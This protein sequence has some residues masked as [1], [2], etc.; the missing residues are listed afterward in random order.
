MRFVRRVGPLLLG[1]IGL[2]T[3]AYF[4]ARTL[5]GTPAVVTPVPSESPSAVASA[6]PSAARS[7]APVVSAPPS[8][9]PTTPKIIATV[10]VVRADAG[11]GPAAANGKKRS[12]SVAS[13]RPANGVFVSVDGAPP[14]ETSQDVSFSLDEKSHALTFTC[15]RDLCDPRTYDVP[16]GDK[17][18]PL[19]VALHIHPGKLL[20]EGDPTHSYGIDELP[21]VTVVPGVAA[22]IPMMTDG[23]R[24]ITVFDRADPS[25]KQT[26]AVSAGQQKLVSFKSP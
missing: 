7:T 10:G 8:A 9:V 16:A 1:V 18:V 13:L 22:T 2:G 3:G 14:R 11:G 17:D 15:L 26:V 6:P 23:R 25:K 20:V 12:V 5:K 19:D 4:V 21:T 24:V